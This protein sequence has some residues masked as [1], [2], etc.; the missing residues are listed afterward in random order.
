MSLLFQLVTW[1]MFG[2]ALLVFGFAPGAVLRLIVLVYPRDD[3]RRQE[4]RAEV[5]AVP[6]IERPFW[7]AQQLEV[8][9]FEG[10]RRRFAAW[11]FVRHSPFFLPN[12]K[13]FFVTGNGVYKASK[14]IEVDGSYQPIRF[15]IAQP[16]LEETVS[17]PKFAQLPRR[18]RKLILKILADQ[19]DPQLHATAMEYWSRARKI[20][21]PICGADG[22]CGAD[23]VVRD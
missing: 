9:L 11:Q 21:C 12:D 5:Y 4:L 10:S 1:P 6:L 3:P 15:A 17:D 22:F 18:W 16:V 7:V 2:I 19:R 8:A 13:R 23:E 14:H 20:P